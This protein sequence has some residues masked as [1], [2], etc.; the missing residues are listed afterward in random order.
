MIYHLQK[1]LMSSIIILQCRQ[2]NKKGCVQIILGDTGPFAGADRGFQTG[3]VWITVRPKYQL[4]AHYLFI[5][6]V[7]PLKLV[8]V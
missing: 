4:T 5:K 7:G 1:T 2:F 6:L 8:S 3:W